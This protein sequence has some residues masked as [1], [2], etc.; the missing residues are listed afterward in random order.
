MI[1]RLIFL[2]FACFATNTMAASIDNVLVTC[3]ACHGAD[4][5]GNPT[6]FA[7][8]LAGQR[9]E[10][11]ARQLRN[12]KSGTRGYH[13]DDRNGSTMRAI[14]ATIKDDD[15]AALS[16]H[17]AA[18]TPAKL[19]APTKGDATAGKSR[20]LGTCAQCH[21]QRAEGYAQLQSPNLAVLDESYLV[22]QLRSYVKGWRGDAAQFDQASLWMRSIAA[23]VSDPTELANIVAYISTLR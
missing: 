17:I 9:S 2:L 6:L 14:A 7:P 3:S 21:G 1:H 19:N 23:Q 15:I 20:Y 18:L 4:G 11:L 10:Y 5:A 12:F 13:R 22:S 16:A 8:P